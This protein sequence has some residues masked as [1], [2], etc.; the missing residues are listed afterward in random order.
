M[1]TLT[2]TALPVILTAAALALLTRPVA[3][4]RAQAPE[5]TAIERLGKH[6]FFDSNL[7]VPKGRQSCASCHDPAS[8]WTFP[9]S[10]VNSGPVVAPGAIAKRMGKVRTPPNAYAAAIPVFQPCAD[11]GFDGGRFCGGAFHDGRA[12]GHGAVHRAALGDLNV[13]ETVTAE[14]LPVSVRDT[15]SIFLGPLADQALNPLSSDNEQN[16]SQRQVC[17]RIRKAS[18]AHLYLEAFGEV[19]NCKAV[20]KQRPAFRTTFKRI[21]VA[22]SAYQASADVNS[23][24]SRRD[25]ALRQELACL[26]MEKFA[27]YFDQSVCDAEDVSNWGR[28]PLV[29]LTD[30]ENLGHDVFYGE[31]SELNPDG[32]DAQCWSCHSNSEDDDGTELEQLYTD[33]AYHGI[34]TPFNREIPGVGKGEIVGVAA[35][36]SQGSLE[37]D[38]RA[39]LPGFFRAPT[40]RNNG[41]KNGPSQVKAF[42]HNGYF[43][44]LEGII[45]FYSTRDLKIPCE[46]L[47]IEH[48]TEA[49]AL[50]NDCWPEPEFP[51]SATNFAGIGILGLT[52]DQEAALAAYI[53]SLSDTHTPTP[54]EP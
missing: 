33:H 15:Y 23:F 21:A 11:G 35:H 27:E 24:S 25:I 42:A 20:P 10:T 31:Q 8:G 13:S 5:L 19:P 51:E 16:I 6:L 49:E 53:R 34:G 1:K 50:A 9:D 28:F 47:D 46:D 4:A 29:G 36:V 40:L 54:P 3:M 52:D 2:R 41:K 44:S 30:E 14:D 32:V 7:S 18:Y 48:A 12:E 38:R 39:V 37:V 22:L 17:K 26:D 43:K 45:H